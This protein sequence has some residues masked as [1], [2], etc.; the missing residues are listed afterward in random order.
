MFSRYGARLMLMSKSPYLQDMRHQFADLLKIEYGFN[1]DPHC[2]MIQEENEMLRLNAEYGEEFP[3]DQ[4]MGHEED[5]ANEEPMEA[6]KL[7][8][9]DNRGSIREVIPHD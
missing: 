4:D 6:M 9:R 7:A 1:D 5:S 8:K 2:Q 3:E